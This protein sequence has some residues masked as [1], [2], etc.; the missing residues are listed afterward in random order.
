MGNIYAVGGHS[1][2][3]GFITNKFTQVKVI[4]M[5]TSIHG[6]TSGYPP[7]P[8]LSLSF[9]FIKCLRKQMCI[10][11]VFCQLNLAYYS[12]ETPCLLLILSPI[13]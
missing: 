1:N 4:D 8:P 2:H 7:P 3:C 13:I 9:I 12:D 10:I 6:K 5:I 11:F